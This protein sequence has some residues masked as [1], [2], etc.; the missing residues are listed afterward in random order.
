MGLALDALTQ[1]KPGPPDHEYGPEGHWFHRDT[2]EYNQ[3]DAWCNRIRNYC[4]HGYSS[5][6]V[7][8]HGRG[9]MKARKKEK[10]GSNATL[11]VHFGVRLVSVTLRETFWDHPK[12]FQIISHEVAIPVLLFHP[13]TLLCGD[14]V[15]K[16]FFLLIW[17]FLH[18]RFVR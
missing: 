2:A 8:P 10:K 3:H 15:A 9:G 12:A 6:I 1:G 16:F 13:E 17:R 14:W 18:V 7:D 11:P 4:S 5:S